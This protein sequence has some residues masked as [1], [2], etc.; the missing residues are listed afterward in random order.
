[1]MA[2]IPVHRQILARAIPIR[3]QGGNHLE[4]TARLR[5]VNVNI[6]HCFVFVA[7]LS[8]KLNILMYIEKSTC[9]YLERFG[10]R[11]DF[12]KSSCHCEP[13]PHQFLIHQEMATMQPPIQCHMTRQGAL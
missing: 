7:L 8:H 6:S 9:K 1:V 5:K 13:W 12:E 4:L 10:R 2:M 11:T 3:C